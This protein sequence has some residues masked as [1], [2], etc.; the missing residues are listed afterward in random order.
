MREA[1]PDAER[2]RTLILEDL[3]NQFRVRD[4]DELGFSLERR[5]RVVRVWASARQVDGYL[6]AIEDSAHNTMGLE[7]AW[8]SA[9]SLAHVHF[10]EEAVMAEPGMSI[11]IDGDVVRR[12]PE[13]GP[14]EREWP[15]EPGGAFDGE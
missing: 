4:V 8:M 10:W 12:D 2:L 14:V 3:E 1:R 7:T 13:P 11:I 5:G 15:A 6:T 9:V